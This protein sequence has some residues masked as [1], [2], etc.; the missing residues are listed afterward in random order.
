MFVAVTSFLPAA[1]CTKVL[2]LF[3]LAAYFERSRLETKRDE[4]TRGR[5]KHEERSGWAFSFPS[6]L[7]EDM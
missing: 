3:L 2:F 5:K 4:G 6:L 7:K 1:T